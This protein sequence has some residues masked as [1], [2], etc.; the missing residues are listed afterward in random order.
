MATTEVDSGPNSKKL[1]QQEK[2]KLRA[3]AVKAKEH[4]QGQKYERA[5]TV[6]NEISSAMKKSGVEDLKIRH[7]IAL[8]EHL[9]Q[10]SGQDM[11]GRSSAFVKYMATIM[12]LK[13][14]AV[15][16]P[17]A[18]AESVPRGDSSGAAGGDLPL[19]GD[20]DEGRRNATEAANSVSQDEGSRKFVSVDDELAGD[21]T[22]SLLLY[23]QAVLLVQLGENQLAKLTLEALF[24]NIMLLEVPLAVKTCV[25]LLEVYLRVYRGNQKTNAKLFNMQG[26]ATK[27][28]EYL[29][30]YV[31]SMASPADGNKNAGGDS[32]GTASFNQCQAIVF[33]FKLK[34]CKA[35]LELISL[36]AQRA[37]KEVKS[38][39]EI[40]QKQLKDLAPGSLGDTP[41]PNNTTGLILKANLEYLRQNFKKSIKLLNSCHETGQLND[42]VYYNNLGC[43]H[44]STGRYRTASMYFTKALA[45]RS[46]GNVSADILYNNGLQI[47][48]SGGDL[49]LAF[50][51]FSQASGRR[52]ER[53]YLWMR[54]A[55]CCVML[56][57]RN[58]NRHGPDGRKLQG[59]LSGQFNARHDLVQQVVGNGN[60]RRVLL[61]RTQTVPKGADSDAASNMSLGDAVKY[62]RNVLHLTQTSVR[63]GAEA[64]TEAAAASYVEVAASRNELVNGALVALGYCGLCLNHPAMTLSA[65]KQVLDNAG[66]ASPTHMLLA[67]TYLAESLCMLDRGNE[68]LPIV[69]EAAMKREQNS[70][71]EN[72]AN[73]AAF[74][75]AD[76]RLPSS[77]LA[78]PMSRATRATLCVNVAAVRLQLGDLGRAEASLNQAL[79]LNPSSSHVLRMLV[80]LRLRQGDH[81]EAMSLLKHRRPTPSSSI[82]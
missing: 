7:N 52:L 9:Q 19:G 21:P 30:K 18:H 24:A 67:R 29:E 81:V 36:N 71:P 64:S 2:A 33:K 44:F 38:A 73:Q 57:A 5:I 77:I 50:E 78:Q 16:D 31:E 51:C 34:L 6:L 70:G 1:E 75:P 65:S 49:K 42:T 59:D 68:A 15:D 23:N 58:L 11:P 76:T 32:S 27:V 12:N 43:V 69:E 74:V 46:R 47:L 8:C 72:A 53:P 26:K 20:G 63:D 56:H 14:Q 39:L 13:R 3:L 82:Y 28:F 41:L 40:Y 55:E 22:A 45:C 48:L 66:A 80:Y 25:L 79:A 37:K 60:L 61:P 54:M 17:A 10:C 62:L 35:Q 4:F